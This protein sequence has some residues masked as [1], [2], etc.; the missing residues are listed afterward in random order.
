[1]SHAIDDERAFALLASLQEQF[2]IYTSLLLKS[3]QQARLVEQKDE[4][5]LLNLL[6]GKADDITRLDELSTAF[7]TERELL[8]NTPLGSF[9]SIDPELDK[10]LE[11]IEIALQRL[12]ENE[13]KDV[14][15]LN[16]LQDGHRDRIQHLDRGQQMA[17]AY[18][19][20][21]TGKKMDRS[22]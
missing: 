1:M 12:V 13:A 5:G 22:V 7:L 9:S 2:K 10:V 19:K 20:K 16:Q 18:L 15:K 11:A 3:D 17:T 8:E 4:E 21:P 6:K 14:E